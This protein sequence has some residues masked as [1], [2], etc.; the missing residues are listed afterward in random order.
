MGED[1][2]SDE[3]LPCITGHA[4]SYKHCV[5]LLQQLNS[6]K[7]KLLAEEADLKNKL[8]VLQLQEKQILSDMKEG[9]E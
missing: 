3:R 1:S 5:D 4:F 7:Q 6:A 2:D 9:P 8:K